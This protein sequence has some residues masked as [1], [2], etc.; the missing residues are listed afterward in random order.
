MILKSL[1]QA[2]IDKI[3]KDLTLETSKE[4]IVMLDLVIFINNGKLHTKENRK[5]TASNSY[6]RY[7]SAHPSFT[8]KGIVKSQML[9]LRR[10]CSRNEDF[11]EAI[12]QLRERCLNSGYNEEVVDDI[13]KE[14]GNL[15]R[16]LST[17]TKMDN[18]TRHKIRWV[19][20]SHSYSETE[21]KNFVNNMNT[22][23]QN[24]PIRF[25]LIK[26]TAPTLGKL[27]FNNNNKNDA[28]D[29][30]NTCKSTCK[31]CSSDNK[32]NEKKAVSKAT[33]ATYNIDNNSLCC[34]SGIYLITC[35]CEEQYVG[36]TTVSFRKRFTEHGSKNT[37]V[38]ERLNICTTKPNRRHNNTIR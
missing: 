9:R 12:E 21:V 14:A 34:N 6:L 28:T 7:G 16:S 18:G 27:L 5:E 31:I 8:F 3:K 20:M 29:Y 32:G 19:T 26:T 15:E 11:V 30:T 36:K 38:K 1:Y 4:E 22:A 17:K 37:S 13:L 33:G 10:L 24:R 2:F 35:K 23:L 25:E